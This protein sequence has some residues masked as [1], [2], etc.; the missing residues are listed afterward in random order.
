MSK[1]GLIVAGVILG[2]VFSLG[3][4]WWYFE[5]NYTYQGV[6]IDP[7]A[8]APDF[9]LTDQNGYVFQLSQQTGNVVLIFFGYTNCPDVCPITLSE[10]K[11][12]KAALGERANNVSFVYITVDPERDTQERIREYLQ[13]FD[14]AFIGLTGTEAELEPVWDSYGV[15]HLRQESESAAGYLI[16]HSARIYA[17]DPQGHWRLNYP[18]GMEPDRIAQDVAHLLKDQ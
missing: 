16:D 9:A 3:G 1:L 10:Y 14:P 13:N 17:I 4:A 5:Q 11:Q 6:L 2:V 12:I 18:F 7:P 8:Q 15:Y